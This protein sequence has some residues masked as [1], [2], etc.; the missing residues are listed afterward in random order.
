MESEGILKQ[1]D[2]GLLL[3]CDID[4]VLTYAAVH[5]GV[6]IVRDICVKNISESDLDNLML[7]I[8]SNND[9]TEEFE[10][11]IEKI[12][13]GEE[14]HFKNLKVL[15]N[16]GY[17][18]SLTE[19]S[20]CQV[21]AGIYDEEK[22]LISETMNITAL[23]F[24]Q[25]P[26]LQYT[27]EL[28]AAFS[29]PNHPVVISM[30]RLAAKYLEKWTKDPSLAGYQ[31]DDPNRVKNMAAAAYAAI[32][33]NNITYAEPPSSFEVFGQR[34]RLAD[35]VLD[36]HLGTCM[37]MTLL[38]VACLEAMGLNPIMVMM[39]G[40]IFAG[41]WLVE[42][43]FADMIMDD[44]SQLEKRMS[45]GIHEL[46]VVECTAM[47]AGKNIS[48]DEA[49][50]LAEHHISNYGNFAFA[51]DVKRAR[52]MGIRPLP[53]R[54]KTVDGFEVQHEERK[55]KEVTDASRNKVEIF[56]LAD[57]SSQNQVTK[58]TQWE[59][60]LLDLSLRNML[61]NMRMTKA[62]VPL[63]ASDVNILEDALS[64]GEEF[65]VM[66]RPA[67]MAIAGDVG[68]PVEALGDM[69]PFAD[70][71]ALESKHKRLHSIYTEKELNSCL[72]KM[73]R[74]A[75]TSMEENGAS[76]L[77][78]ALGLLR[79]FERKKDAA[80][81]YAPI[82]LIPIEIVRKSA[83]K[84][85]AMHMRDE[86]AQI[87]ITL[88]EFLKQQFDIQIYG[89]NPPPVDEHGLD[90]L[91]IFAIIRRAVMNLPMWDVVE[92]GFIGNFS[93][94]QFVMWNDIH[95]NSVFLEK[96]KIVHSLMMGAVEWDCTIPKSV[97]TDEAYLPVTVD[98]SQLRAINMAA[99]GVS[100]VLHGP[101]G[102]GKSQTITAMVAN[103][104]TKGKTVLFVAE[105]RAALEVVQKR[106]T[107]LGIQDF[108][109]ELHSNKATKK[110][111]L[112][113]LKRGLEIG[114]WEMKT[115]YDKK[116]QDIRKMRA[117][118]DA[119]AKALHVKRPFG[120][121]LRQLMDIYEMIPE[122][123]KSVRFDH[124]YA[125]A[126]T[127]SDLEH[128]VHSLE[129]LVAAG[130]GIGHPHNHPLMAVHKTEYSQ[131]LKFDLEPIIRVYTDALKQFQADVICF[132]E[133]MGIKVPVTKNEWR[134][135]CNCARSVVASEEI[136]SFLR[137]AD[138]MDLKFMVPENYLT[139]QQGFSAKQVDFL[140]KWNE[141]F[142][143]MDMNFYREKYDQ[144]NKKFFGKG[145]ALA[146][147]T[148]ELQAFAAFA[149]ETDRIPVYLTD[150]T[151][152]QQEVKEMATAEAELA[153]EWKQIL[154]EYPTKT[155]LQDYKNGVKKQ[156][157]MMSQF[158]DQIRRL[159]TAGTLENC[160]QFAKRLITGLNAVEKAEADAAELLDL[161][162][163][164]IEGDWLEGRLRLCNCVLANASSIK[165]WIVYQQFAVE[166]RESGLAPICDAY[167]AGLPHD[168]VMMVYLRSIYRT[169]ILSVIED[170][171][172]LNDFTGIG[173]NEKIEQFKKL[174]QEF[175]NLT[176]DEMF[177]KLT[178]RL[179]TSYDS[180][181]ISK[182]LNILR[183]AISSNGR[184]LSIRTLF[185]QIPNI[186]PRLCPCML[187]SPISAAQYLKT[188]NDLFDIVIFDEASQLPTCK[189]V[190]V[191]ARGKNAVI[192]GDPNQMPPTSFF[193]GNKV[194]EDN[195]DIEDLDSILDDCLALGMPSAY[196][197]WHYRSRH[198]SL[199]AFSN[200]EFYE[201]S[202]L[203]FPSVNDREKRVSLI[204]TDGFFDRGKGR[205]NEGEAKAI[206]AEI[207][208]RYKNPALK[209][210]TIGVVTFNISQQTLIE[211]LLQEEYQKDAAF[212]KWANV[213]EETMFVKN[214]ENVQG[215]ER[216]VILFSV[217]FGPDAEGKLL[218]NF[219][220]LNKDGGW[221]RL[222]VA[223]SRARLE[224]VVFTTM[225]ADM[226]DL[227]RT[228]SKG[229]EGLKD[230]LE[231][232]QKGQLQG[233]YA[234]TRVQKDQGIMEH[235]C[236]A[237]TD[238]GYKY[239]KAVGHSKFKVDIAV[240][241]PY[242]PEE[243]LLGIM[244]DGESYRQSSNTKDREVAQIS[245]LKG[246]GWEL[247]RIWTMDWWDNRDKEISKLVHLLD[248][249]K[250]VAYQIY[251]EN[252][253]NAL[254]EAEEEPV[255][256]E[257][258]MENTVPKVEETELET[259]EEKAD[260]KKCEEEVLPD[261]ESVIAAEK[262][263]TCQNPVVVADDVKVAFGKNEIAGV[264]A[265]VPS[266]DLEYFA[267]KYVS[268]E[269][270]VTDLSTTD[271]VKKENQALIIDKMQQIIDVE[272][273]I[274]YDRLI[275]KT[276]RAFN[277]AR[278]STQT[279]EATDKALKKVSV[280]MNKQA[281][282]KFYW[283]KDQ[284]PNQY[285]SYRSEASS[286]D[287]RSI[288]E[289]CQQELKNAVCITLKEQGALDKN[290][291]L[292]TTIRTMGYARSSTALLAAAERG[293]K[294]GRKTG[295][296]VQDAKQ[297]FVLRD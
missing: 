150:I 13:L 113:R 41:V 43:S 192:V 157:Q 228:K 275:K 75:K 130:K 122:L 171:P 271:Y 78:L 226:I 296:I 142:L 274:M 63:L 183:R 295:E 96:N 249:K 236:Q 294:Y 19:R 117:E 272:A 247:H 20:A 265:Q 47:C 179:P 62:V 254:E 49:V 101:P 177:Y 87:N 11:G 281:G 160:I 287:K 248:E 184:G 174:D 90:M 64:D 206:V 267:E 207:L 288:D 144:A 88:L 10:L 132:A 289:I 17:L 55:E 176:K 118:L 291:L 52:S 1:N 71:I 279:L 237:I 231:F 260:E 195:L 121:T 161:T 54:V 175:M 129:R 186:L 201:N 8:T 33:Q 198:E 153:Y 221:K 165:D 91:K 123:N 24:D 202:M 35:A 69:G 65:R 163:D 120:K 235:I 211:D 196:L 141:N 31:F 14:L 239:Q 208:R 82:V 109:L 263:F 27:P 216:D 5:N 53:V 45:R 46:V 203:T 273:P 36:Q 164:S 205:V 66:P 223:V 124:T 112:D 212:D 107:A 225:T 22:L 261:W 72:T 16:A 73:Y 83:S 217:A 116:I 200:Q 276:L 50:T 230:F 242:N 219:G 138:N 76:T 197:R 209:D 9:L 100:F 110:A 155:A 215:D 213:G 39:N 185:E 61:I 286:G 30:I 251:L 284:D 252:Q 148:A 178:H 126:L 190:G 12:K 256:P 253:V 23:A 277:I 292:K 290:S 105:K 250:E 25:W 162:F 15:V 218:L 293:L 149:V 282:V 2:N 133:L 103:A 106:L 222:N 32:Q 7:R 136:P 44:P 60:K 220:P 95:N 258:Q 241:N 34:I 57:S 29:M 111:V 74:S 86:D 137:Q 94:S 99:A 68:V 154:K 297:R 159:E 270:E 151:I 119:Y 48:F 38:Y 285:R 115:D 67:D 238:G 108:C 234:E 269:I 104:L 168:E 18:A 173:F 199:I 264:I 51:I 70:F 140:A 37:D 189:A 98:S 84:G 97:D 79:W 92:V 131:R 268:A 147:L 266:L 283:R 278:S 214:L 227:R 181:E 255:I 194:D 210:Q 152:Y 191:L 143:H 246:L 85:Y 170:E 128:Q 89:L 166:C 80:V 21:T 180:V 28:L 243:Y 146:S 56:E 93:F 156:L 77:Y 182:E 127:E 262:H 172:V 232:A 259:N 158:S 114:A 193:A 187:M 59:R 229:V 169:I 257:E 81:R 245:V 40:H 280:R 135:I 139:K 125:G 233:E 4:D 167:E 58:L 204:K 6:H 3:T 102:T 188:E 224:M 26:G 145:K 240:I 42:E 134:D 244:L